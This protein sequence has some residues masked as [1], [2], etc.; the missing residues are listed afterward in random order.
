MHK[1][2]RQGWVFP[3]VRLYSPYFSEHVELLECRRLLAA[4]V[5]GNPTAYATIQAAVD[6]AVSGGTVTVDPGNYAELVFVTKPLTLLG[7]QAGVDGR[8]ATAAAENRS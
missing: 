6:A 2:T 5:L 3:P 7:A 1:R 8:R 4:H